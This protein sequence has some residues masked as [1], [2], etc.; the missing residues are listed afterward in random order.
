M[1]ARVRFFG[2]ILWQGFHIY[3][4]LATDFLDD[5][6]TLETHSIPRPWRRFGNPGWD[7]SDVVASLEKRYTSEGSVS[8]H[9]ITEDVTTKRLLAPEI[10]T[11]IDNI[12]RLPTDDCPFWR[13]RC[14]VSFL[15]HLSKILN[16]AICLAWFRK[17]NRFLFTSDDCPT[18]SDTICLLALVGRRLGVRSDKP[19]RTSV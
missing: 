16:H 7:K 4:S 5:G 3:E 17:R 8:T 18:I 6:P 11:A 14:K 2:L 13:I 9:S 19:K 12:I 1:I 15:Y 10:T